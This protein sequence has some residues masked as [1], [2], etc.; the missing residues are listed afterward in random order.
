MCRSNNNGSHISRWYRIHHDWDCLSAQ[1]WSLSSSW[2]R[3]LRWE[4]ILDAWQPTR[5]SHLSCDE[6]HKQTSKSAILWT[7]RRRL[8]FGWCCHHLLI[9]YSCSNAVDTVSRAPCATLGKVTKITTYQWGRCYW[10]RRDRWLT[11]GSKFCLY[12]C[13][14]SINSIHAAVDTQAPTKEHPNIPSYS[15]RIS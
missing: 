2:S 8:C 1:C 5:Q 13:T 12:D 9:W 11:C 14:W 15:R 10:W 3:Q 4:L 7:W 6:D